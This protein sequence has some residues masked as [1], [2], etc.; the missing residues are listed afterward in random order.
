MRPFIAIF[1]SG[2]FSSGC[3]SKCK[4]N[5]DHYIYIYKQKKGKMSAQINEKCWLIY[6][7]TYL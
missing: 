7:I 3:R 6:L 2:V 1:D 5:H 4:T